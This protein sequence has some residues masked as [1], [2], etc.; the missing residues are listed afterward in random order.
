MKKGFTLVEVLGAII[1]LG[2]IS[3]IVFVSV[4]ASIKN[5]RHKTCLSQ[6]KIIIEAAKTWSIDNPSSLPTGTKKN[7]KIKISELKSQGYLDDNL[8]NPLTTNQYNMDSFVKISTSSGNDYAYS[9]IYVNE[10][11][12]EGN[13]NSAVDEIGPLFTS[14]PD[15]QEKMTDYKLSVTS[16]EVVDN[17]P[18][19][20]TGIDVSEYND[21]SVMAWIDNNKLYI[22]GNGGVIANENSS[23]LFK[24]FKNVTSI[25]VTNLDTTKVTSMASMF[26]DCTSLT[27]LDL[28]GYDTS[29]VT[30]MNGM[31]NTCENLESLDLNSFDTSK[32]TSMDSMFEKCYSLTG[33]DLSS[34]NTSNVTN[35]TEMFRECKS[36]TAIDLSNFNTSKVT[37]IRLMFNACN[38]L[39][40][41]DLSS[42]D[43]SN[44]T[45]MYGVFHMDLNDPPLLSEIIFGKKWDTSKVETMSHMFA[46]NTSLTTL[47]LSRFNTLNVTNMTSMFNGNSNLKTI[48]ASKKFI[49]TNVTESNEMF[50]ND[51]K[52]VGGNNTPFTSM[53]K[54]KTYARIDKA[55]TPGY[56]TEKTN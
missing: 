48:Y 7:A 40:S 15:F 2:I 39:T 13:P 47:D 18:D 44:V 4:D 42:F 25:D 31:F 24:D 56:F 22:G 54:D 21:G 23:S 17:I 9:V 33:L 37:T 14:G 49:T 1:I 32:V 38:K 16:I 53:Y 51:T 5:S 45:E 34:F 36:L 52:L 29:N 26:R 43:T 20:I 41:L 12:C 28:S 3:T 30:T 10:N 35:M 8:K 55:G 11:D 19:G 6:E 27:S 50:F 46:Y